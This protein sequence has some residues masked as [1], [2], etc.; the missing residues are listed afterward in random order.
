VDSFELLD[1]LPPQILEDW[2]N[3]GWASSPGYEGYGGG[4]KRRGTR[5]G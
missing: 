3:L 2:K 4:K 1:N 5:E